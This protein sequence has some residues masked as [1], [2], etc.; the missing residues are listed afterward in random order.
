MVEKPELEATD[1]M[2]PQ[3]CTGTY[4]SCPQPG[5]RGLSMM[6][7][8]ECERRPEKRVRNAG[9]QNTSYC[10][11]SGPWTNSSRRWCWRPQKV[12]PILAQ[13]ETLGLLVTDSLPEWCLRTLFFARRRADV[14]NLCLSSSF[15]TLRNRPRAPN[16]R[17]AYV[18]GNAVQ[19]L[20]AT[21][22]HCPLLLSAARE[23]KYSILTRRPRSLTLLARSARST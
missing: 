2:F 17:R 10:G 23:N 6:I 5:T 7:L 19:E 8:P 11:G 14:S 3:L 12:S 21:L 13:E 4:Q 20:V 16:C 9:L 18:T 15:G 1:F 22:S